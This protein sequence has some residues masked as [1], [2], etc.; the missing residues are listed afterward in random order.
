L[1]GV[2]ATRDA[3]VAAWAPVV[4][5][6]MALSS[7]VEP[8]GFRRAAAAQPPSIGE[9]L[10][11]GFLVAGLGGEI[12]AR[13]GREATADTPINSSADGITI[14][15][16]QNHGVLSFE[17]SHLDSVTGVTTSLKATITMQPCPDASGHFEARCG[18]HRRV[19]RVRVAACGARGRRGR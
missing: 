19:D 8:D 18:R 16:T 17:K 11:G 2:E 10:F 3:L 5:D 9:G 1:G 4:A 15:G 13:A 7:S 14:V 6:A 12:A